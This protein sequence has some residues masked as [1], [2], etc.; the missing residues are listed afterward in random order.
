MQLNKSFVIKTGVTS[1]I[2]VAQLSPRKHIAQ[3]LRFSSDT[4]FPSDRS[5]ADAPAAC[6]AAKLVL[7]DTLSS[8]SGSSLGYSLLAQK[9]SLGRKS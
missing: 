1:L 9:F 8:P 5:A 2:A 7:L 4:C 6:G 3:C